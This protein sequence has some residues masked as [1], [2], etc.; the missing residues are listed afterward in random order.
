MG[1]RSGFSVSSSCSE[2]MSSVTVE[3]QTLKLFYHTNSFLKNTLPSWSTSHLSV[4]WTSLLTSGTWCWCS[5][6]WGCWDSF[7][8]VSKPWRRPLLDAGPLSSG[9][10]TWKKTTLESIKM[11]NLRINDTHYA[12]GIF[13]QIS[14]SQPC[15]I[16]IKNQRHV[17]YFMSEVKLIKG[18]ERL[19]WCWRTSELWVV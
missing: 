1:H 10:N 3:G 18:S 15:Y 14:K 7:W 11:C 9:G 8:C 6:L 13:S 19:T 17:F 4:R 16:W 12:C 2:Y 5:C